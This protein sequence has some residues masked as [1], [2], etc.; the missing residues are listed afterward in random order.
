MNVI[1]V[2]FV[3]SSEA[4]EYKICIQLLHSSDPSLAGIVIAILVIVA[5]ITVLVIIIIIIVGRDKQQKV[6]PV[7]QVEEK[8]EKPVDEK[9][10]IQ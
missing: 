7:K 3:P 2:S 9:Q 4:W 6:C 5:V 1:K 8:K 10:C